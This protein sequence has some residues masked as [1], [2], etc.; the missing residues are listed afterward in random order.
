[1]DA[2]SFR[3]STMVYGEMYGESWLD[4]VATKHFSPSISLS[5]FPDVIDGEA[6]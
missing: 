5:A 6:M 1:M 3:R 2:S 4:R